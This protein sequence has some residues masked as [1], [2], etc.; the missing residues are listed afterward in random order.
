LIASTAA[1]LR[2]EARWPSLAR[3]PLRIGIGLLLAF[4]L[5]ATLVGTRRL[6]AVDLALMGLAKTVTSP[7]LDLL[8]GVISYAAAAEV[9]LLLMLLLGLWLWRRGLAPNRAVAP[10]LFLVTLPLEIALKLT[11][12]QPVPSVGFYRRTIRYALFGLSTAQSFPSGHATRTAF[13]TVLATYLLVR[14]L[15]PRRALP[16]ALVLVALALTAGWSR[17]YLGYHWPLDVIGGFLL[18]GGTASIAIALLEPGRR[19]PA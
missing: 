8:V 15:G 3:R 13:M 16:I 10:L 17:I 11:L 4:A 7:E 19:R 2:A 1:R 18:G 14:G 9:S 12:P 5:V 6:E